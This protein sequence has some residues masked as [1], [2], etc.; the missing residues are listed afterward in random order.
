MLLGKLPLRRALSGRTNRAIPFS[1]EGELVLLLLLLEVLELIAVFPSCISHCLIV[2]SS[3]QL[4]RMFLL[5][6][7]LIYYTI[8]EEI[9]KEIDEGEL[10]ID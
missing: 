3:L 8:R 1:L 5:T 2:P 6:N 7:K 4:K 10:I 9:K